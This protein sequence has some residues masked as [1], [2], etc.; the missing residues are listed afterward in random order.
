MRLALACLAVTFA[1]QSAP[2]QSA[3]SPSDAVQL[4]LD[5]FAALRPTDDDLTMY[6]L[7][8]APTLA[9]AVTRAKAEHRP[10]CLVIIHAKYGDLFSGHC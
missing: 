1:A 2:S 7:D 8:W 4:V 9:D 5:R 10:V 3:P 6:R